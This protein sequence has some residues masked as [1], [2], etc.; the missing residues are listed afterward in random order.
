MTG[1]GLRLLGSF[2]ITLND[3]P[4]VAP[5]HGS[6][7][8]VVLLALRDRTVSRVADAGALAA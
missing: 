8:L 5:S 1:T 4:S 7:R 6:Q 2:E 3:V